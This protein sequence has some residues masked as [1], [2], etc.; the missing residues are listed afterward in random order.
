MLSVEAILE[1]MLKI[2]SDASGTAPLISGFAAQLKDSL[3]A[4]R[5]GRS[6]GLRLEG[7]KPNSRGG[8]RAEHQG[9]QIS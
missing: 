5:G 1:H 2:S 9:S 8:L 4:E 6:S 7:S 3:K